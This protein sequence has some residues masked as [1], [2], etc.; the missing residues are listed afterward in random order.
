VNEPG[1]MRGLETGARLQRQRHGLSR[2]EPAPAPQQIAQRLALDVL[3]DDARPAAL[4]ADVV[5]GDDV[6]VGQARGQAGLAQ[7]AV[8]EIVETSRAE[9]RRASAASGAGI[10]PAAI[11]AFTCE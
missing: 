8:L 2:L 6:R 7:E 3:H 1:L 4:L 5:D 10:E 9:A 11:A